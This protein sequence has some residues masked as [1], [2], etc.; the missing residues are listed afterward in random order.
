MLA[1]VAAVTV[2]VVVS[3]PTPDVNVMGLVKFGA[4]PPEL[5]CGTDVVLK[6][7]GGGLSDVV[8][9]AI[10]SDWAGRGWVGS[11][12][13]GTESVAPEDGDVFAVTIDG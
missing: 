12:V 5:V 10:D 8:F 6:T 1:A 2:V 3:P 4:D 11:D 7:A 9:E 13:A